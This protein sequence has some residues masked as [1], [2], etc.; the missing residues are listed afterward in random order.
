MADIGTE[1]TSPWTQ[2]QLDESVTSAGTTPL[3]LSF[4][5]DTDTGVFRPAANTLAVVTNATE[6]VRF[7]SGG[8]VQF[9]STASNEAN[10]TSGTVWGNSLRPASA[11]ATIVGWIRFQD[12]DGT[13]RWIAYF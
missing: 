11:S 9:T 4:R 8:L 3:P 13:S 10:G 12:K 1:H 2:I 5:G 7:T 6:V